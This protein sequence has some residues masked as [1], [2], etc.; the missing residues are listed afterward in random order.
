MSKCYLIIVKYRSLC[1]IQTSLFI[2]KQSSPLTSC[3]N[4]VIN[5]Y[6]IIVEKNS[7]L[8][9]GQVFIG[10]LMLYVW[11]GI[12]L[13]YVHNIFVMRYISSDFCLFYQSWISTFNRYICTPNTRNKTIFK[14]LADQQTKA[15]F[16][17]ETLH[18]ADLTLTVT[19]RCSVQYYHWWLQLLLLVKQDHLKQ[20][21]QFMFYNISLC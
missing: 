8:N 11:Y 6:L 12:Q 7:L 13:L 15:T 18:S 20:V 14:L 5:Y 19:R 21:T 17:D 10:I 9:L 4:T 3:E 1:I 2:V 16:T